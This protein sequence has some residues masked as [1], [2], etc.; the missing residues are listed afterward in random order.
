[1]CICETWATVDTNIESCFDGYI[2]ESVP[3]VCYKKFGRSS[4]GVAVYYKKYLERYI[5]RIFHTFQFGVVLKLQ[6]SL[7]AECNTLILIAIYLPPEFS[8]RYEGTENGVEL[9]EDLLYKVRSAY[10]NCSIMI[11]GDLNARTGTLQD[12]IIDDNV[13]HIND[14]DQWYNS[15]SFN[16]PRNSKD[17]TV[18]KAGIAL[19]DL[20][21]EFDV[22]ILNG[23]YSNDMKESFTYISTNGCSVIDYI[24]LST[25][26]M[27]SVHEFSIENYDVSHHMPLRIILNMVLNESKNEEPK[28]LKFQTYDIYKWN[29]ELKDSYISRLNEETV[30]HMVEF[31]HFIV[32][33][34]VDDAVVVLNNIVES[35]AKEMKKKVSG[36]TNSEK[37]KQPCWWNAECEKL[38]REKFACLNTFRRTNEADDFKQYIAKKRT[39]KDFCRSRVN[40]FK[41]KASKELME[42]KHL[43]NLFW[44]KLKACIARSKTNTN[45]APEKLV[46]HFNNLYNEPVEMDKIFESFIHENMYEHDISCQ[47]CRSDDQEDTDDLLILNDEISENEIINAISSMSSN[48]SPGLDGIVIELIKAAK[49]FYVPIFQKLFNK[50]LDTEIFLK[51]GTKPFCAPYIRKVMLKNRKITVEFLCFPPLVKSS[52]K[53]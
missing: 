53:F 28:S 15:S 4:G 49:T 2:C 8:P 51:H 29:V 13:E 20:C 31:F 17:K 1:M 24:I 16:I 52:Q 47:H 9:L 22:H 33:E 27:E 45:I 34:N 18:N 38:K 7:L 23:R 14:M 30:V 10:C 11:L 50:M 37:M 36:Y 42:V 41:E 48:K 6:G 21:C 44:R 3:A 19:I 32:D 35:A 5:E 26:M 40:E 39:F 12:Y 25:S 43:P 46:L